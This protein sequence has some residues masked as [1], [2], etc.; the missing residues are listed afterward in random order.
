M[1]WQHFDTLYGLCHLICTAL[2]KHMV[3]SFS[4]PPQVARVHIWNQILLTSES[5]LFRSAL[6]GW[7]CQ[8]VAWSDSAGCG[9][10]A[11]F[12]LHSEEENPASFR[13]DIP[14]GIPRTHLGPTWHPNERMG[15]IVIL[16]LFFRCQPCLWT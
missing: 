11:S 10:R 1:I 12:W 15:L 14:C 3:Q 4:L 16:I 5:L 13:I 8:S 6:S 7:F 9:M 2:L